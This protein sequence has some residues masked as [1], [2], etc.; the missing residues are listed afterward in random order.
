MYVHT[1]ETAPEGLL[2]PEVTAVGP[3]ILEI[4]WS[5]PRK[6]NGLISSYHVYRYVHALRDIQHVFNLLIYKT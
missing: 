2:P 3:N 6:P 4:H 5:P 1:L